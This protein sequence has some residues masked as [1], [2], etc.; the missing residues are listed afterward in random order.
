MGHHSDP[1]TL[2]L[3]GLRLRGTAEADALGEHMG[4]TTPAGADVV[5]GGPI[6]GEALLGLLD[7]LDRHGWATYRPGRMSGWRLTP[8]G[9]A[10][11]E[12]LLAE[13]LD[14]LGV[15]DALEAAHAEFRRVNPELLAVCTRWQLRTVDG[16]RVPN[17]HTD[18]DHDAAVLAELDA[19]HV[20]VEPVIDALAAVLARYRLHGARLRIALDHVRAGDHDWFTTPMFPSYHSIWFELHEDQLAT[21]GI[22][23][24]SE[25]TR[26]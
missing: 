3:L 17:D 12:R 16:E 24:E 6:S 26:A 19:L 9:R 25:R 1:R 10:E 8:A 14:A 4:L 7:D 23:R 22:D 18:A 15:R 11:G 5:D 13:E 21:L 20:R 2:A